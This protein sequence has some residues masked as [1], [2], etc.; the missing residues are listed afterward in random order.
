MPVPLLPPPDEAEQRAQL[1]RMKRRATGFLGAS[2]VLFVAAA[3]LE[4]AHP[5][6]GPVRATA[7]AATVGGLADWVAVT[8]LFRHPLGLPIPHTAI[9]AAR[10]DRIGRT[11]GTFVQRHFLSRAVLAEKLA[12]ARVAEH[13]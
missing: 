13:L 10:K 8:A 5:W 11:L 12:H 2:S 6:L 9:I 3:L 1:R 4:A 7:E